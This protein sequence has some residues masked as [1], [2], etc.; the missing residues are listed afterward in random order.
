[1]IRSHDH[2]T[3]FFLVPRTGSTTMRTLLRGCGSSVGTLHGRHYPAQHGYA[4]WRDPV[5]RFISA[6]S[7]LRTYPTVLNKL[8][9]ELFNGVALPEPIT[10]KAYYAL[11]EYVRDRINNPVDTDTLLRRVER[12]NIIGF[13]PQRAWFHQHNMNVLNFHNFDREARR[14]IGIF[15]GDTSVEIP[16]EN[17]KP[18]FIP[19]PQIS[20]EFRKGI[21]HMYRLDYM[22]DPR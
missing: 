5:E 15:G 18:H 21:K 6:Y 20:K 1:M 2:K 10:E 3:V 13:M 8:F 14:L 7:L 16:V 12:N 11:P 22:F 19:D 17:R 4:F 9:P